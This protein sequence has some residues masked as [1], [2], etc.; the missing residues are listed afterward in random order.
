MMIQE[1][2]G[3]VG[4]LGRLDAERRLKNQS[5]G[6]YVLREGDEITFRA[7]SHL[8]LHSHPYLMTV[9][10]EGNKI[11][12]YLLLK[13]DKGWVL[14][15]DDPDLQDQ[16]YTYLESLSHLLSSLPFAKRA[17]AQ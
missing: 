6:T 1:F 11:A 13:T 15:H 8:L 9:V 17:L 4:S 5:V 2:P 16:D 14:Y 12:D 3:W 10:E 7:T